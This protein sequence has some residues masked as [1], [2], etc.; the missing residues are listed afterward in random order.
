MGLNDTY[1]AVW[2]QILLMDPIPSL[3]KVFSLLL[4]D[5]KQRKVGK[6]VNT[7][8]SALAVKNSGSFTKGSNKGKSGRPQCIHCGAL[9]H[10]VDKCYK[11]H[12][13]PPGYKSKNKTQQGGSASFA[14]NVVAT[15]NCCE[16]TVNLTRAEYQQLLGLLNSQNHFVTQA[17][18][19]PASNA[20]QVAT[21][22]TQPSLNFQGH[23][24]SGIRFFAH[25]H[26]PKLPN[27]S[28]QYSVFSS[29]V[30]TSHIC[31][32]DWILDSGATDHM[33]HSLQFFTSI[34]SI[35]HISVKL[36]NGDMAKVTHIG[37]VKLSSTLT[38]ENVLCIPT[39]FFNL[40]SISKLTQ[41]PSCC[42]IFLSHFCF[43][44]STMH[45][46]PVTSSS[47]CFC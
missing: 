32:S 12:G 45:L 26:L 4:Q 16:E 18:Q 42:C 34:T 47:I 37:T 29:Q 17:P 19:E 15:D 39:F 30:D 9:G 6:R 3:S 31:S 38:L 23:E 33:V 1:A 36:P 14:N 40:V 22:I 46:R 11:L 5:E 41:S 25:T 8:S 10:V 44:I 43:S 7:E 2:G 20:P 21:I 28:L 13:Y 27:H 24:L 35:V